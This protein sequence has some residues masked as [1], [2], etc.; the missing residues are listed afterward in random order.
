MGCNGTL[1]WAG[2]RRRRLVCVGTPKFG[3][4]R[5]VTRVTMKGILVCIKVAL[6]LVSKNRDRTVWWQSELEGETDEVSLA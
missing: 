2:R 6:Q 5:I 1:R 4:K 3:V